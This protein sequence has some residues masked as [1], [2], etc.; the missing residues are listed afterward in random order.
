MTRKQFEKLVNDA[1]EG[2]P[3]E[4]QS[5]LDNVD[6]VVEEWPSREHIRMA[7]INPRSLLFGLYQGTPKTRR[8]AGSIFPDKITIFAGPILRVSRTPEQ[9]KA[10][11]TRTVK[12][13]I[14]HHFGMDEHS[15][16]R[17]GH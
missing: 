11:V 13:E 14:A 1:I 3:E 5:K 17:R 4:F 9:V 2:L 6:F 7:K 16:R 8:T 15:I 10:Q 12:H